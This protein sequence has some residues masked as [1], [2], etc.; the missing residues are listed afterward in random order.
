MSDRWTVASL[1]ELEWDRGT[2]L[3][4]RQLGIQAFGVNAMRGTAVGDSVIGAH[5]E[6]VEAHEELYLV[7]RGRA[8]FTVDGE[9]IDAPPGTLVFVRPEAVR[10]AVAAEPD[11][12]V[13]AMGGEPGKPFEPSS[14][15]EWGPLGMPELLAAHRYEE[16]VERYAGLLE[17][18]PEHPGVSF[19]LACL[20]SLAGRRD[21]AIER[22]ARAIELHPKMAEYAREDSDFDAVRDDPRF[23]QL[24][25]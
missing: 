12:V 4:R 11:T 20:L 21:E 18:F 17:R 10:G 8:T 1:D 16:A 9:E 19:N 13:L 7:L 22:L 3:I 14:W 5:D 23:V 25:G 15:E 2:A 24:A 6:V